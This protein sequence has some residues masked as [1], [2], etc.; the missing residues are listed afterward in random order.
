M[1]AR[2]IGFC[3]G[4]KFLVLIFAFLVFAA[5]IYSIFTIRLD[6]IQK[7]IPLSRIRASQV[8]E[9]LASR[10]PRRDVHRDPDPAW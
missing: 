2:L 7:G 9:D 3:I 5:G 1:I 8:V 6:T 4:N 10:S